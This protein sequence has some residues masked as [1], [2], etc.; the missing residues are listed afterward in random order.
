M[1]KFLV[2]LFLTAAG[3]RSTARPV[4]IINEKIVQNFKEIYPNALQVSWLEYPDTYAVYF[5]ENG[6][7]INIIFNKDGSFVSSSRYYKEEYLPYY[8][9]AEIKKRY[10]LK[11]VYGISELTSPGAIS[12][13]IKL[14]DTKNW[15]TIKMD[16]EGNINVVEK[17]NK[18]S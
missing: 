18:A 13:F 3:Y 10:P 12:Y 16:S 14:E 11:K 7:K 15:L 17:L 9:L 1:K 5:M 8:L 2:I 6:I 4:E